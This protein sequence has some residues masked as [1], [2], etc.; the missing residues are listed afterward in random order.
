MAMSVN[1]F[2]QPYS[3][4]TAMEGNP[5]FIGTAWIAPLS[6]EKELNT[7]MFNVTLRIWV[8]RLRR[9]RFLC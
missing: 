8:D 9:P 6:T 3:A 7:P 2:K 1:D 5:N 4:G